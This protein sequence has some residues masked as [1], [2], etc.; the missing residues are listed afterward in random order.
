MCIYS[1]FF[2]FFKRILTFYKLSLHLYIFRQRYKIPKIDNFYEVVVPDMMPKLYRRYF[3]MYEETLHSVLSY[4]A[5]VEPHA[6][7]LNKGKVPRDKKVA[8]T[9]AY[10]GSKQTIVQ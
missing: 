3:R 6:T 2:L 8:M 1:I 4:L 10:L 7:L 9:C 5:S